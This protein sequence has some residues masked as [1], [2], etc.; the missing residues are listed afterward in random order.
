MPLKRDNVS[1]KMGSVPTCQLSFAWHSKRH[2]VDLCTWKSNA[3]KITLH[4]IVLMFVFL[5][6]ILKQY[7]LKFFLH[8]HKLLF[9]LF[10]PQWARIILETSWYNEGK[11]TSDTN[12]KRALNSHC[13]P[14]CLP[15]QHFLWILE[16]F[17]S[18]TG[19]KSR[20]KM[21]KEQTKS[22]CSLLLMCCIHESFF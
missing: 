21:Y 13:L 9:S 11:S 20:M 17:D 14:Y 15:D 1:F 3:N 10:F 22:F 5:N 6:N 2:L 16:N 7:L 19:I 8:C 4:F 18:N 12:C